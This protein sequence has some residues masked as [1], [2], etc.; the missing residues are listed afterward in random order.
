ML[1]DARHVVPFHHDPAHCDD[2]L[3][4]LMGEAIATV[5]PRYRVTP[6]R[7]GMVFEV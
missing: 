4:R 7:E 5:K 6:G 3:D 2:D 1:T